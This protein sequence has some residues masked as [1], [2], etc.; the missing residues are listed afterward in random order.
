MFGQRTA[1]VIGCGKQKIWKR[2]PFL[3]PVAARDAYTGPLF[4]ASRRYAETFY[5]NDWFVLSA[6]LGLLPPTTP[7]TDYDAT[8]GQ[9][10]ADIITVATLRHQC[11]AF[12]SGYERVV[13]LAGRLYNTQLL[14]ALQN[15]QILVAP[16]TSFG[17]FERMRW[18]KAA[19]EGNI[20]QA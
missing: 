12:L 9:K 20:N 18:L 4:R 14:Q 1:L 19:V 10:S 17:L 3:G 15:G 2:H 11:E 6:H 8:F 5:P 7:M 13:S 16:L